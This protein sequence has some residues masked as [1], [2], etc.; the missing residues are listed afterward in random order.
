[1]RT[2]LCFISFLS[3]FLVA[4]GKK[5]PRDD[6]WVILSFIILIILQFFLSSLTN[7]IPPAVPRQ[8]SCAEAGYYKPDCQK[9]LDFYM[10]KAGFSTRWR[11]LIWGIHG[12]C[13]LSH[14]WRTTIDRVNIGS[15]ISCLSLVLYVKRAPIREHFPEWEPPWRTSKRKEIPLVCVFGFL[16]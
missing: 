6:V 16:W 9:Y 8:G 10:S 5:L 7:N 1:M 12:W 14:S 2:K 11:G 3:I 13:Q 4:E 15:K